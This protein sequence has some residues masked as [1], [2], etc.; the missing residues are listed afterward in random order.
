MYLK[1]LSSGGKTAMSI[2]T[3]S[4]GASGLRNGSIGALGAS[5][6]RFVRWQIEHVLTKW[7]MNLYIL[8]Q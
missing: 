5:V 2:D 3:N 4:I 7:W 8:G 1:P 6:S